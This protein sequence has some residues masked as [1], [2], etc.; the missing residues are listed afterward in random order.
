MYDTSEWIRSCG[1]SPDGEWLLLVVGDP[2]PHNHRTLVAVPLG[3]RP[4]TLLTRTDILGAF[5]GSD[6]RIHFRVGYDWKSA[7][8][9]ARWKPATWFVRRPVPF[10]SGERLALSLGPNPGGRHPPAHL[11]TFK[12]DTRHRDDRRVLW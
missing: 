2:N 6:G 12:G 7:P 8:P 10:I 3:G 5:W 1:W 11:G 4:D 9:P